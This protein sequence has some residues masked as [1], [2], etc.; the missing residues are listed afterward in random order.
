MLLEE[1]NQSY[2]P[3]GLFWNHK[4]YV[5]R[6]FNVLNKLQVGHK[7]CP[8]SL[9]YK[10]CFVSKCVFNIYIEKLKGIS[11][12]ITFNYRGWKGEKHVRAS[13]MWEA[14][15]V[16]LKY[17]K[18]C[19]AASCAHRPDGDCWLVDCDCALDSRVFSRFQGHP[20]GRI[21]AE[22][23]LSLLRIRQTIITCVL[24]RITLFR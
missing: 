7:K 1:C 23:A 10:S 12:V 6:Y 11:L 24:K 21:S 2:R 18:M 13:V 4:K 17:Y 9:L 5:Y 8:T 14:E 15:I 3:Y 16:G 19:R 22:W 20:R